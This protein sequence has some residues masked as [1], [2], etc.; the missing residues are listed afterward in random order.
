MDGSG[1]P[2]PVVWVL[3]GV[4]VAAFHFLFDGIV[5]HPLNGLFFGHGYPAHLPHAPLGLGSGKAVEAVT[6]AAS[7]VVLIRWIMHGRSIRLLSQGSQRP[8]RRKR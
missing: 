6:F 2:G 1:R 7:V 5:D 4:R 8:G 3:V